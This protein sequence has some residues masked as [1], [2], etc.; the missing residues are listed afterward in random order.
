MKST[1][2]IIWST[3]IDST[4]N[5][6]SIDYHVDGDWRVRGLVSDALGSGASSL[7]KEQV[8]D[9]IF[10]DLYDLRASY[11][12]NLPDLFMITGGV[13]VVS[14]RFRN[15]LMAH[16]LGASE[17]HEVPLYEYDKSTRRPGRWFFFSVI[18]KK[19][20]LV[21]EKSIGIKETSARGV[22]APEM[23]AR[24]VLAVR[25]ASAQGA[26]IWQDPNLYFRLFLTDRLK[27]AIKEAG[28]K[29]RHMPMRKC[30]VVD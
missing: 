24:D 15:L 9:Y 26:D 18:E 4:S 20:T 12:D 21:P 10:F 8:P 17:F 28:I 30:V 25:A 27:Q 23:V 11:K 13:Y 22:Y 5:M 3:R 6:R 29:V 2:P 7:P 19:P 14:E 16:E 1:R